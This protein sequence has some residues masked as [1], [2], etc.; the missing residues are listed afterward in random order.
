M[1]LLFCKKTLFTKSLFLFSYHLFR[2]ICAVFMFKYVISLFISNLLVFF[3]LSV[4][5]RRRVQTF[6]RKILLDNSKK[7]LNMINILTN[8]GLT[9][10]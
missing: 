2:L 1:Y 4:L 7:C 3:F 5:V 10:N 8:H 9:T 6:S